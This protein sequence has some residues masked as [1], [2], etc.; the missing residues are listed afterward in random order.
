M[1]PR[2]LELCLLRK[3]TPVPV[4]S[5]FFQL[6]LEQYFL[7]EFVTPLFLW[8]IYLARLEV[9]VEPFHFGAVLRLLVV[10]VCDILLAVL[11]I[12]A[13]GQFVACL[14]VVALLVDFF[15]LVLAKEF[16]GYLEV[17][18]QMWC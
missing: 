5:F 3:R 11:R 1:I 10:A 8:P 9:V 15:Y 18:G 4:L 6:L 14:V 13:V 17:A 7:S 16:Q 2:F 12:R